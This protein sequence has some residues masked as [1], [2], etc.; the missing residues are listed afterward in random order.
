MRIQGAHEKGFAKECNATVVAAAA[1]ADIIGNLIIK[2]PV[3]ATGAGVNRND[4]T[5][6]LGNKHNAIDDKWDCFCA[7]DHRNL[8][9]PFHFE[10]GHI[11]AI[12]CVEFAEALR[13]MCPR[14]A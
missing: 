11:V 9:S 12:D 10:L 6:G 2:A 5:R 4:I 1:D 3:L 7:I 8:I 13:R 14:I